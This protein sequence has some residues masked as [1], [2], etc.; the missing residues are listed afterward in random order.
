MKDDDR[1]LLA[2]TEEKIRILYSIYSDLR[3]LREFV[4]DISNENMVIRSSHFDG[5]S[6]T[7]RTYDPNYELRAK[8]LEVLRNEI[9]D[10]S[11]FL[12]NTTI[13]FEEED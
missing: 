13:H 9:D 7:D 5:I 3:K 11:Q 12:L 2:E 10:K 6:R 8:I 4:N 1:A